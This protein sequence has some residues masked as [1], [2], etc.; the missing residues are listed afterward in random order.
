MRVKFWFDVG[1]YG[2]R[3]CGFQAQSTLL[4]QTTAV[5]KRKAANDVCF[6]WNKRR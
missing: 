5:R 3:F 2:D 1:Y 6:A 4:D